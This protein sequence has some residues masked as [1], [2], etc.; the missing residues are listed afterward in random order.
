MY[1]TDIFTIPYF[2]KVIKI[3]EAKSYDIY[4]YELLRQTP[5]F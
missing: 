3:R 2:F 4:V 1:S 5:W